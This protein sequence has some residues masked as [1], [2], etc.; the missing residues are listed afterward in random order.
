MKQCYKQ[1]GVFCKP[2]KYRKHGTIFISCINVMNRRVSLKVM[3]V[4]HKETA[5][6]NKN[7]LHIPLVR[8]TATQRSITYSAIKAFNKLSP[9]IYSLKMIETL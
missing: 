4:I 7:H 6:M 9:C 8:L 1:S 2:N 3:H 5:L